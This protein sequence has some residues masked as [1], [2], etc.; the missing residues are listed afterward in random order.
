MT[1]MA[2]KACLRLPKPF[3][4]SLPP[5]PGAYPNGFFLLLKIYMKGIISGAY[6]FNSFKEACKN[7]SKARSCV[8]FERSAYQFVNKTH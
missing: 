8:W 5:C 1:R 3:G 6:H 4:E 2:F 7:I